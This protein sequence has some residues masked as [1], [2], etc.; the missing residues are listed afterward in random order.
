MIYVL[1]FV[2]TVGA[3]MLSAVVG[4]WTENKLDDEEKK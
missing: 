2:V 1:W 4:L 3:C